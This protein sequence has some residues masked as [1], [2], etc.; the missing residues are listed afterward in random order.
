MR[1]AHN[2]RAAAAF[3]AVALASS[4]AV[5]TS[6]AQVPENVR[7]DFVHWARPSLRPISDVNLDAPTSDL[8]PIRKIIGA[9]KLVGLSEGQHAAAEPLEFRNRLFKYLVENL[10]FSAI[11]IE[12]GIVES[13]ALNEYVTRGKGELDS[14]LKQ[15]FSNGFDTFQQN[16]ELIRWMKDHNARLLPGAIKVQ[17]YGLDVPGSPGNLDA[18]RGPLTGLEEVLKYLRRVDPSSAEETQRKV[19]ALLPAVKSTN[20]YGT[21]QQ[22]DRDTFTA[23]I[24]DLV[25]LMERRRFAYIARSSKEDYE[26]AARAAIGA[27]QTDTWFRRMPVGWKLADGFEWTQEGQDVRNRAMFDNLKWVLDRLGPGARMLVYGASGHIGM[28][29]MQFPTGPVHEEVPFGVYAKDRFGPDYIAVLNLVMGGEIVYCSGHP[30]RLMPLK[31]PPDSAVELLFASLNVPR[32][33][34]DLRGAPPGVASWLRQT[35][36]HWN[37]FASARFPTATA[38]DAVY[39]VSPITSACVAR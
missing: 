28:T 29:P 14:V 7:S 6:S 26:W 36:D 22:A 20:G 1:R 34:V 33:V 19:V 4:T 16:V 12:S 3:V 18:A 32:Y 15:G 11:G 37:G 38:F 8:Q 5:L 24:A 31:Q 9:A 39:F 10:G 2:A 21:L 30:P 17:I 27:R 25:S 13:R 23:A 35:H